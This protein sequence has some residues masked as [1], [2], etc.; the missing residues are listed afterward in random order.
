[1]ENYEFTRA[2]V[3]A[4]RRQRKKD[5][6]VSLLFFVI[7]VGLM[8]LLGYAGGLLFGQNLS[9]AGEYGAAIGACLALLACGIT[10]WDARHA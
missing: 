10:E 1:V 2:K 9:N 6:A 7:V 5:L 3:E 8:T 4:E